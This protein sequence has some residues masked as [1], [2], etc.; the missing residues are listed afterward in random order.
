MRP[1][2]PNFCKKRQQ[3]L[4]KLEKYLSLKIMHLQYDLLESLNKNSLKW[5]T[6]L[7]NFVIK[8]LPCK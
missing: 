8:F 7:E 3:S 4:I 1:G 2:K 5:K 6:C